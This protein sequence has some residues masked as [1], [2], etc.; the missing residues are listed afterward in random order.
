MSHKYRKKNS[1]YKKYVQITLKNIIE[2][3]TIGTINEIK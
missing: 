3:E 1:I 2:L